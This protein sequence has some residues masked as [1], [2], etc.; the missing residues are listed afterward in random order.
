MD[1]TYLS[2]VVEALPHHIAGDVDVALHEQLR[3]P[4]QLRY[5]KEREMLPALAIKLKLKNVLHFKKVQRQLGL[6]SRV[7]I[8]T[9]Q[10][11]NSAIC[12]VTIQLK[13]PKHL[14]NNAVQHQIAAHITHYNFYYPKMQKYLNAHKSIV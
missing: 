10:D 4:T 13:L 1:H 12:S 5:G 11:Y 7:T 9:K 2:G 3:Y 14:K 6:L 8:D